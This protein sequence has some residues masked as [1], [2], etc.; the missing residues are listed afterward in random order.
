MHKLSATIPSL[1]PYLSSPPLCIYVS[2]ST[3]CF[4]ISLSLLTSLKLNPQLTQVS[5]TIPRDDLVSAC[6]LLR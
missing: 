3:P 4:S 5:M 6:P 1:F 2:L